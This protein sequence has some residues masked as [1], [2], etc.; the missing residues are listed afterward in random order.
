M[1]AM[2]VSLQRH[3]EKESDEDRER[4]FYTHTLRRLATAS[5]QHVE[6]EEW[7]VASLEVEFGHKIGSGGLYVC[8]WSYDDGACTNWALH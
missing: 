3:L 1:M 4:Q 8:F 7:M 5:G 2:M 6:I